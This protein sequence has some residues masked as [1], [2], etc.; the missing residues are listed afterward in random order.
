[1]VTSWLFIFSMFISFSSLC[2]VNF[3]HVMQLIYDINFMIKYRKQM[4]IYYLFV[5]KWKQTIRYG[6]VKQNTGTGRD[7]IAGQMLCYV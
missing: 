3:V 5:D 4:T 2:I 7:F 6:S 1:M